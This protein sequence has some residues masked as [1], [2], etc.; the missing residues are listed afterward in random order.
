MT[1]LVLLTTADT[2]VLAAAGAVDRL[3]SDAPNVRARNPASAPHDDPDALDAWLED[4]LTDAAVV[5]VR[6]LGGRAAF[7]TLFDGLADR[8]EERGVPLIA[9]A[10]EASPDAELT[11]RSTAP[12]A[13]VAEAFEYLRA[14]GTV[15]TEHV[16]RFLSDTLLLTGLGFDPPAALP[17]HG[18]YHPRNPDPIAAIDPDRP[19]IGVVFYRSHLTS[20]N[21]G[22]VDDLI[23]AIE[24]TG[25]QAIGLHCYSLRPE[26]D[27]E[28]PLLR[29]L[30]ERGVQPDALVLTV[31]ATGGSSAAD[32]DAWQATALTALDVPVIQ[33]LTSTSSRDRW[34]ASDTGLSPMDTAMQVA[35]PEFDGRLIA[36]P[37]SFK[38]TTDHDDR[39]GGPVVRYVTDPERT[40]RVAGLAVRHAELRHRPNADTRVALVLSNYP[41][42]HSRIG[43]GVGL[44]TPASTIRILRAL[45]A[46]GYDLGADVD[47]RLLEDG[48]ALI[49]ALIARGGFDEEFLTEQQLAEAEGLLPVADYSAWFATLPAD[50][51]A[52]VQDQWGP[53]PGE[54][55]VTPDGQHLAT[56]ALRFGN[57]ILAIQ[58]PRGFGDDP[59]TIYHSPDLPPTHQ[60]LASYHWLTAG[61]G[62][63]AIVHVGKHGTLEWLPGKG[64]GLS[65]S[66]ATDAALGDVPLFYPFVVNDPGEGTQAKRRAHATVVDHLVPPMMRAETYDELTQLEQLLDEYAELELLDPTK[67]PAIQQQVWEL[68][69]ATDVTT[70]LG[71]GDRP[72]DDDAFGELITHVDGYL[73]TVKDLQVRDGLHVLGL[74]PEDEQ[75]RG[76]TGAILRLPQGEVP[77]LRQVV[78]AC[79][80]IDE[81]ALLTDG[82]RRVDDTVGLDDEA[83]D[84]ERLRD[85]APG[86]VATRGDVLDRVDHLAQALLAALHERGWDA[87][88]VPAALAD[89]LGPQ[90][91]GED[92]G[93]CAAVAGVL[94]FACDEVVPR[95][96]ACDGE[97]DALL[98]GLA[99]RHVPAGP[100]GS[101]TRGRLDVLPTGRNFHSV[102]PKALPSRLSW[103]V[104]QQLADALIEREVAETG[105]VPRSV[106]IVVWGT[107][108][109]RTHGD[110]VAEI[111]A[112]LG[113]RPVWHP[114]TRRVIDLEVI[115]LDQLGRP[116][117]DVTVRISG[118]FRDAFPNLVA[119]MDRAVELVA[120]RGEDP[121]RNH[122]R[123]HALA[124]RARLEAEGVPAAEAER[125]ST[126]RIFG[127][128][129]GA[130][131]S[132]LLPLIDARN[133]HDTADLAEV[134][135][136]WSG[137]A[138]GR[139]LDG[140]PARGDLHANLARVSVAVKNVDTREHDILDSDDYFQEHGGMVATI[141][142]LT[143]TAPR[144][145]IGDSSD[146][147]SP[148]ARD[149]SQETDRIFR[150]RVVNPRW[151]ASMQRHGYKGAF[152]LAAT[153][154]YLFGYDA[155]TG[156]V[157]DWQYA[158]LA[159]RYLL[160]GDVRKF[161]ETSNPWAMRGI[162]ERLLE[163][164]QRGMWQEPDPALLAQV[165]Q[166]LLDVEGDLE[167]RGGDVGGGV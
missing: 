56:A 104:G 163:A 21:T 123:A 134:Y 62:A 113:V 47:E 95:V 114:E 110:D 147:A 144:A 105:E 75:L 26:A 73:C 69:V 10:G 116:R 6:L 68:L 125:R 121:D 49:H 112:L 156:V 102:D 99:G 71:V 30:R 58:P 108:N 39:V 17:D 131:G 61:F 107:A 118:F 83:L 97:V 139:G 79:F 46:A 98:R 101:P 25:A 66:C 20:G 126:S 149:L 164:A 53:P 7:P 91:P 153:V 137:H 23:T 122:V 19:L 109:M 120:A 43:N 106:G 31:L 50:L 100:S 157:P 127:A 15:N 159:E 3:P 22:F 44:D 92:D 130:Y 8:C 28:V 90:A 160:D 124:D 38:E 96:R 128:K 140:V 77:G 33:A 54:V 24:T 5:V 85:L 60:Y 16:V 65:A 89:V 9:L 84:L 35:L 165:Q 14:G 72:E 59:V 67:L 119:L 86:P 133:W 166:V 51:R 150:A 29:T 64:V 151:I 152:E 42:K 145:V 63:H 117:V 48:D 52:A 142:H 167:D 154:D 45:R 12:T 162:A 74:P 148:K 158:T 18:T 115:D 55:L 94:R 88:T 36:V 4:V 155:T 37:F 13:V 81:S 32:A 2:E 41:T 143:G 103:Q 141:R 129:P 76:L 80:G 11:D 146:P 1:T 40:A 93:R 87:A 135:T 82:G 57:V 34:L 136:V 132:G 78:A 138:Y 27:G 161:L 70:S 111:L